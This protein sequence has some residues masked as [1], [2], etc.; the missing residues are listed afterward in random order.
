MET[1]HKPIFIFSEVLSCLLLSPLKLYLEINILYKQFAIKQSFKKMMRLPNSILQIYFLRDFIFYSSF[2]CLFF[3]SP[4]AHKSPTRDNLYLL[5]DI[6]LYISLSSI[7]S[8]PADYLFA[9]TLFKQK[10]NIDT[11]SLLSAGIFGLNLF[12][13]VHYRILSSF[14]YLTPITYF[15]LL[16]LDYK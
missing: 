10:M 7:L 13:G 4:S 6:L 1:F 8:Q 3:S 14:I 5:N 16:R 11:S 9:R 15:R 2:G 12:R